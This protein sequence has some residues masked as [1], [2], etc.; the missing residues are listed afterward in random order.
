VEV[1]PCKALRG[2]EENRVKNT[3]FLGESLPGKMAKLA[4]TD[5]GGEEG[6]EEA[7]LLR[8]CDLQGRGALPGIIRSSVYQR[9]FIFQD[10]RDMKRFP[11]SV[12][13]WEKI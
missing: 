1:R 12:V 10:S 7:D 2:I 13:L 8:V 9:G 11:D 5:P 4:V 6:A 3:S